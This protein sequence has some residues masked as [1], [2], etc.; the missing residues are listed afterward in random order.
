MPIH[1]DISVMGTIAPSW[2]SPCT[3]FAILFSLEALRE[4]TLFEAGRTVF[5]YLLQMCTPAQLVGEPHRGLPF[6]QLIFQ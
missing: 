1:S 5:K 6:Y 4:G 3:I 2:R